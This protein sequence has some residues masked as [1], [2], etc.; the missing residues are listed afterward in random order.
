MPDKEKYVKQ[1]RNLK[2]AKNH[3]LL[4]RK[5]HRVIKFSR[6]AQLK[7]YVDNEHRS[8]KKAKNDLHKTFLS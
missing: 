8:K 7:P 1:I 5:I 2:Q 6:K 4:L 3:G